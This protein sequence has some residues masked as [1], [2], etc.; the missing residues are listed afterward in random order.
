MDFLPKCPLTIG[1]RSLSNEK[2]SGSR[3]SEAERGEGEDAKR[4]DQA[5]LE[6]I[7]S[8]QRLICGVFGDVLLRL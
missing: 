4:A 8:A 7:E 6:P 2:T 1:G 3:A 5:Q